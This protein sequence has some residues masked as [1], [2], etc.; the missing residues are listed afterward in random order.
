MGLQHP[1]LEAFVAVC[2]HQTV[3]AAAKVLHVTQTAAT[4][5]IKKL[6]AQLK[7]TLFI[8]SRR[9]MTL[10]TEGQALLRYCNACQSLEADTIAQLQGAGSYNEVTLRLQGPTSLMRTRII[11]RCTAVVQH[12]PKLL[13]HFD[14]K[15][16]INAVNALRAGKCDLAIINPNDATPEMKHKSL[17]PER[18]VLVCSPQWRGRPLRSI[19]QHERIID[20][21]PN[22]KMTFRYLQHFQ[23]EHTAQGRHFAN[24]TES[25]AAL[26]SAGLGYSA[27]PLE[28]AKPYVSNHEL[29]I[30]NKK[31]VYELPL[32]LA[33]YARPEPPAY[34]KEI[35]HSIV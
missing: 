14:I 4:Q 24:R 31:S 11:P 9:G 17:K 3:H 33:W 28:F 20:F 5:R 19:L 25:L 26:V 30:L 7:T 18:Y 27:L 6:E 21:N 10:T 12:Y 35:I 32:M 8:R 13:L 23:L 16:D 34:F 29:M 22:D 1:Q 2:Q 15:D